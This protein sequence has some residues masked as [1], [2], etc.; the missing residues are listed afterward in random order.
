MARGSLCETQH[1]L[2]RAFKRKLLTADE[3]AKL[4]PLIAELSPKLNA[5][6]HAIGDTVKSQRNDKLSRKIVM[7]KP[8]IEDQRSKIQDQDS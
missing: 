7:Q 5:Y 6:L 8:K 3:V 2:R 4:Q 1:W